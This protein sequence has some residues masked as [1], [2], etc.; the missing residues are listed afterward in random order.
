MSNQKQDATSSSWPTLKRL[1][2]YTK[3]R[4]KGLFFAVLGMAGYAGVDTIFVS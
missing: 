2:T 1:L 3:G 4:R